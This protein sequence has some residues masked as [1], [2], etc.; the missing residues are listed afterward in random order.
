MEVDFSDGRLAQGGLALLHL[1]LPGKGGPI[2][3]AFKGGR[4]VLIRTGKESA[5][6]IV[7]ADLETEP[8]TY[9]ITFRQ[10]SDEIST[11]VRIVSGDFGTSRIRLPS[12]MVEFDDKTLARI[13]REKERLRAVFAS[14]AP[15]K[16]WQRPFIMPLRGR[17]SGEFGERRILNGSPRSPHG[18]LDIAAPAGTPVRAAAGGRV[19]FTGKFFFYGNFV[20]IDHGLGIFTLY[21]HLD[22]ILVREGEPV[23]GGRTIGLVGSTGRATGPHLHFA[24]TI[25]GVRVSPGELIAVTERLG[26]LAAGKKTR[27]SPDA[28]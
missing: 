7:A 23:R 17:I 3:T 11:S 26:R 19:A 20:V 16:L 6:A 21:A 1:S 24:V 25:G 5:W 18:G 28:P 9:Y 13:G 2:E 27:P 22:S 10:G 12:K 4:A 15:E 8:G 14:S